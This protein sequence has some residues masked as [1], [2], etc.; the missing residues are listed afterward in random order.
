MSI[1]NTIYEDRGY[2]TLATTEDE[3]RQATALAYSIKLHN[4]NA[5]VAL[6]AD[7]ADKVPHHYHQPFD[8]LIDLPFNVNEITRVND[9]QLYWATPYEHSIFIDCASLV[10]ENH[11]T[12]WEYLV[13]HY[14][15]C[16]NSKLLDF[17]YNEI[18]YKKFNPYNEEYLINAVNSN[19]FYFKHS[20]ELALQYFKLADPYLQNWRDVFR[21]KFKQQHI[22]KYYDSDLIHSILLQ[23]VEFD[24]FPLLNS[25]ILQ[26]IDMRTVLFNGSLGSEWKRWTDRL[27]VWAS[28]GAKIKIQNFAI[29]KT[30]YYME[31]EFLT[32]EIFNEHRDHYRAIAK[33]LG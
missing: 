24:F 9:W 33:E 8:Y 26:C 3:Y 13:E 30:L 11:D 17:K 4:P 16:F 7:Y 5:S 2:I 20:S 6:V 32:E 14:D 1:K 22:P 12:T 10:K 31:N 27:N 28:S 29:N 25:N 18:E 21:T 19:I 23:V 15:L